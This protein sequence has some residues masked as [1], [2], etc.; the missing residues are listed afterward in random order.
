[1]RGRARPPDTGS[2]RPG[3]GLR[4]GARLSGGPRRARGARQEAS[5]RRGPAER[6]RAG[7]GSRCSW[8]RAPAGPARRPRARGGSRRAGPA[9]VIQISPDGT[10]IATGCRDGTARIWNAATGGLLR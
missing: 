8:S 3:T 2:G 1:M 7:T 4:P 9:G 10:W 6:G 5:D